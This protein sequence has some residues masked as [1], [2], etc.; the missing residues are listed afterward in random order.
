MNKGSTTIQADNNGEVPEVPHRP[1]VFSPAEKYVLKGII[2]LSQVMCAKLYGLVG[3]RGRRGSDVTFTEFDDFKF[4]GVGKC[5]LEAY[6][7][8]YSFWKPRVCQDDK[9]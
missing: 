9:T 4:K 8:F 1:L 7:A 2:S 5:A 3:G 6:E